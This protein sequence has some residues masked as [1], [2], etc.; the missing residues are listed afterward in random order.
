MTPPARP[1]L[2]P[3]SSP[4]GKPCYLLSEG[5]GP[6]TRQADAVERAQL[7]SGTILLGHARALLH[8]HRTTAPEVRF[9][10]RCLTDTLDEALRVAKS[11]GGR[12]DR[13]PPEFAVDGSSSPLDV[14]RPED[15]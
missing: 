10:A 8:D 1:R 15:G 12:L 11:R 9:L 6:V 3:W 5:D 14:A 4:E 13:E 7:A 2:L